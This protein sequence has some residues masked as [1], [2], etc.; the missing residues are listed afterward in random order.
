MKKLGIVISLCCAFASG[1]AWA[2]GD[3]GHKAVGAIADQ[4]L[5][6]SNAQKR[7]EALLKPGENLAQLSVWADC[8]KG[9]YCG[10]QTPEMIE[11]TQAHPKHSEYHYTNVPF[12]NAAYQDGGVGT[13]DIDIVQTLKHAI[14]VL[15]GKP[16]ESPAKPG[17]TPR[18]ALILIAHLV[19]DIHQPLHV[20]EAY[21][22]QDGKY[23]A[24]QTRAQVDGI[25]VFNSQGGNLLLLEDAR[26]WPARDAQTVAATPTDK[27]KREGRSLHV[28]W[29]VT[30]VEDAMRRIDAK[31]PEEFARIAIG[32]EPNVAPDAGNPAGWPYQ[33]ANE[34]LAVAKPAYHATTVG[35]R[36]RQINR[37][38][39]PYSA[40]FITAAA[41]YKTAN[42]IVAENQ[43][44]KGGYRL[45]A[46]LKAIWP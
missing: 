45:A 46:L 43:I 16:D 5:K 23:V 12:Q 13:R 4:L 44:V 6:N 41:D 9:S 33:W 1:S 42:A 20:G 25:H 24:P 15:Q 8:V 35:D 32:R 34:A 37:R 30:V 29:D 3:Q 31:S 38:G 40:W 27:A 19:G 21:L 18:Q 11:F 36:V 2:W 7:M 28:Y 10:P 26:Y 22:D 39:E 17:L 14:A